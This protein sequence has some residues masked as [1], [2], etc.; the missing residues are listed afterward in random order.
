[1]DCCE[2]NGTPL[3]NLV[4]SVCVQW[5]D[6]IFRGVDVFELTM[7]LYL[8][9]CVE[10]QYSVDASSVSHVVERC[11]ETQFALKFGRIPKRHISN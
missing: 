6:L 3:H 1:M 8:Q 11:D 4:I 9:W 10:L 7:E 2:R 5:L